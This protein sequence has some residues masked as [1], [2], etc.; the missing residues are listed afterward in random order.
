MVITI[1]PLSQG[2]QVSHE[3]FKAYRTVAHAMGG[4]QGMTYTNSYEA[5]VENYEKGFRVFEVDL[6]ISEDNDLIARHEWGESFTSRLGQQDQLKPDRRGAVLTSAEFKAAKIMGQY[7]PLNWDDILDLMELYPDV[8]IVTDS[9]QIEP[10]ETELIFRK[11]VNSAQDKDP[12]LL[13]R[14]VPQIYNQLMWEQIQDI[15]PF[16]S[17]IFTL[18]RTHDSNDE[19]IRFAREKGIAAV[20]MSETRAN[21]YL[22]QELKRNGIESYVHTIN[23]PKVMMKYKR[24]GAYGFYT[25]FMSEKDVASSGLLAYLI[26]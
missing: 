19:V 25:D 21:E 18:Y 20:T 3:G 14:I 22:I 4:L 6:L 16:S 1:M 12:S 13:A 10:A 7:E 24:M 5:F 2:N 23:E 26:R 11:I 9:K 8:Y 15:H 17:V